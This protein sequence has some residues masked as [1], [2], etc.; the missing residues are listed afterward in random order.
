[1]CN[2]HFITHA[3]LHYAPWRRLI[4]NNSVNGPLAFAEYA[5]VLITGDLHILHAKLRELLIL[6]SGCRGVGVIL[7]MCKLRD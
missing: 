2:C 5:S 4:K 1:M 3:S 6:K 7:N